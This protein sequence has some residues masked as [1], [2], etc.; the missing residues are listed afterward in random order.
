MV[1]DY[2]IKNKYTI[3]DGIIHMEIKHKEDTYICLFNEKDY[4]IVNNLNAKWFIK[5]RNARIENVYCNKT[6]ITRVTTYLHR[7]IMGNPIDLVIDHVDRNPLN[8]TRENLRIC[9]RKEN[10]WNRGKQRFNN[11]KA[12]SQY[13]GVFRKS[14]N[15]FQFE[16]S[17][18]NIKKVFTNELAAANY[19]NHLAKQSYGEFANLNDV[20]Y[21][22]I[23]DCEK[24]IIKKRRTNYKWIHWNKKSNKWE[25]NYYDRFNKKKIYIGLFTTNELATQAVEE[26]LL[27]E[28]GIVNEF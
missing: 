3:I 18:K 20:E 2:L 22:S 8:N 13:K 9:T 28:R 4:D 1:G 14:N 25:A 5:I 26:F 27:R 12:S 7:V 6:E 16:F 17:N 24:Y 19:Y 11:G 23:E 10:N 15:H 21:M